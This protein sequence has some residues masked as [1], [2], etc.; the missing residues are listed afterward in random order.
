MD[1]EKLV[2]ISRG[3]IT[4]KVTLAQFEAEYKKIGFKLLESEVKDDRANIIKPKN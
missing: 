1:K 2:E 3:V 4:R